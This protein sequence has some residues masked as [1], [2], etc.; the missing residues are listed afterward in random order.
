MP[1]LETRGKKSMM[2]ITT[3]LSVVPLFHLS[4]SNLY[5]HPSY[6]SSPSHISTCTPLP[7]LLLTSPYAP[8]FHL[9]LS[10]LYMHPSSIYI[11][12]CTLFHLSLH[13]SPFPLIPTSH[14]TLS[15]TYPFPSLSRGAV[16]AVTTWALSEHHSRCVESLAWTNTNMIM[17]QCACAQGIFASNTFW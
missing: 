15:S 16:V 14:N 12:I 3:S 4:L 17:P 6:D 5:M 10:H 7:S 13:H 2:I 11:S 9:S 1:H 8:L